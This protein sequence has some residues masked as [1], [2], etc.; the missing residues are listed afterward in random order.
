MLNAV[1]HKPSFWK[2]RLIGQSERLRLIRPL[3]EP[4]RKIHPLPRIVW[5]FKALQMKLC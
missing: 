4:P 5:V 2:D 1:R 3:E